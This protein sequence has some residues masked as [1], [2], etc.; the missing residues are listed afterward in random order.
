MNEIAEFLIF[1]LFTW[2]I[3]SISCSLVILL[4]LWVEWTHLW[5]YRDSKLKFEFFSLFY[6]AIFLQS[7]PIEL[8]PPLFTVFL[9]FALIFLICECGERVT[10]QLDVFYEEFIQCNWYLFPM[11]VQRMLVIF[12]VYAQQS[13]LIRGYGNIVCTRDAFKSVSS[14]LLL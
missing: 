13:L 5:S 10:E 9:S 11:K 12:I 4:A 3:S 2:T 14:F 1:V 7:N 8:I 6:F